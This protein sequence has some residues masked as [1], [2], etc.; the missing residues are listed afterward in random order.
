MLPLIAQD[1][2]NHYLYGSLIGGAVLIAQLVM[3]LPPQRSSLIALAAVVAV[4]IAKELIDRRSPNHTP[5]VMDA[6]AT[7]AGGVAAVAPTLSFI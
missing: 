6:V 2:A 4:G 7:I 5:D 1:K 3:H